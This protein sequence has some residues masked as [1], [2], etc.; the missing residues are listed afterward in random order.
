MVGAGV[1]HVGDFFVRLAEQ[2]A[3]F[4]RMAQELNNYMRSFV[5]VR[6]LWRV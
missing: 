2:E 6:R 5:S 3:A 4:R 1:H